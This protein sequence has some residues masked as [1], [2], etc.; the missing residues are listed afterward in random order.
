[1]SEVYIEL[2]GGK[3]TALNLKNI[4]KK[5]NQNTKK[6]ENY[7]KD[8]KKVEI[9]P[10]EIKNHKKLVEEIKNSLWQKMDY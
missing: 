4:E 3:Q 9:S 2:R 8:I 1:M 5:S 7:S 10:E 6:N